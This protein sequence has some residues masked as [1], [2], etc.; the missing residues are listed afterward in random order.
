MRCLCGVRLTNPDCTL[1]CQ[2]LRWRRVATTALALALLLALAACQGGGGGAQTGAPE[3]PQAGGNTEPDPGTKQLPGTPTL[4]AGARIALDASEPLPA[5]TAAARPGVDF[6]SNRFICL[7]EDQPGAAALAPYLTGGIADGSGTG[8]ASTATPT[9]GQPQ[10]GKSGSA[11]LGGGESQTGAV[12]V[13]D[14][15]PLVQHPF[16]RQA[17]ANLARKYGLE[18]DRRVFYKGVDFAVYRLPEIDNITELDAMMLKVLKENVGLVQA[19]EYDFFRPADATP[20][21]PELTPEQRARIFQGNPAG[22]RGDMEADGRVASH[23]ASAAPNDPYHLNK[24]WTGSLATSG[25]WTNWRIGAVDGQAWNTT[26]GSPDVLVAVIDTGVRASHQDLDPNTIDPN[27]PT[28]ANTI[29]FPQVRAPGVYTDL[30]D[31]DN[32]PNDGDGHGTCCAGCIGAK[33]NNGIG[34]AGANWNVTILPLKVFSDTGVS[35]GSATIEAILLA[36]YLGADILSMSLGSLFPSQTERL[37]VKLATADGHLVIASAG[38]ENTSIPH[39]PAAYPEVMAVGATTLVNASNDQDFTLSG[40]ALPIATRYDARVYFSNYGPWVDIAAPGIYGVTTARDSDTMYASFAGTSMACPYV[41]GC[42]A[43]LWSHM[44]NPTAAEV[45]ALLLSSATEMAHLNNGADP[46]G[47]IDNTTNGTVRFC[48]AYAALQLYNNGNAPYPYPAP[49]VAWHDPTTPGATLTGTK[50]LQVAI[51]PNGNTIRR[52]VF[53]TPVRYLGTATTVAGSGYW[54]ISWDTAFEFNKDWPLTVTAYDDHGHAVGAVINIKTSNTH[55]ALSG[56]PPAWSQNFAGVANDAIPSGWYE[57]DGNAFAAANTSWGAATDAANPGL[58]PSMHSSGTVAN[59]ANNSNDWLIPPIIDLTHFGAPVLD[60]KCKYSDYYYSGDNVYVLATS[61]DQHYYQIGPSGASDVW[62]PLT[63]VSLSSFAGRE[64]RLMFVMTADDDSNAFTGLW[65]DDLK[66]NGA[67]GTPPSITINSPANGASAIGVQTINITVGAGT[68][69]VRLDCEPA[70]INGSMIWN[71]TQGTHNITWDSRWT[72][73]GGALLTITALNSTG[74]PTL[75]SSA[76]LALA[77]A[78]PTRNPPWLDSFDGYT[79][80]G[81][82]SGNSFISDW[83]VWWY[84][85]AVK[86]RTLGGQ[87]HTGSQCAYFGPAGGG[88]Y[89]ANENDRLYGPVHNLS[90]ATRPYLRLWHKL[91]SADTGDVGQITL[92]RYDGIETLELPLAEFHNSVSGWTRLV[93]DLTP[94]KDDPLRLKF[95]F[96]SD[97]DGSVGTGWY[98]DDYEVLD[99]NPTLA[100]L[101]PTSGLPGGA[102]TINGS[103]FGLVQDDSTV[104]FAA[105]GGGRVAATVTA[106]SDTQ[107]QVT[108]PATVASGNV[109]VNVLGF[110]SNGLPFTYANPTLTSIVP[111]RITVGSTVTLTGENF[112]VA[113]GAGDEVRFYSGGGYVAATAY[114]SWSNAQIVCTVPAGAATNTNGVWVHAYTKDSNKL[115]FTVVLGPPVLDGLEQR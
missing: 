7:F 67:T 112:G 79:D 106:W 51:T 86:W 58:A 50:T 88:N 56:S 10:E 4:A 43:L 11:E 60:Y 68:Q 64:L 107:I 76:Q 115:P 99:A 74:T 103:H 92:V 98:I 63:N 84:G 65:V 24:P 47:F 57:F 102:L 59:Y 78:N 96:T 61:D 18:L 27:D 73:N 38:N 22:F 53:N 113:R 34:L 89:G 75:Q 94:Y 72:Y 105:S 2:L 104:T 91:D 31:K 90:G 5:V 45:K 77:A 32:D 8:D 87:A 48:N 36:D 33:G 81:G 54:E 29:A 111:N 6:A 44:S 20:A 37:A 66:V 85:D 114:T 15:A 26:T 42:A 97:G 21:V 62:I 110:D 55:A 19:V 100:S 3:G 109:I 9:A 108:I 69:A 16:F 80:L 101:S 12:L 49:V 46:K 25:T 23:T 82:T 71:F 14:N 93:Y 13:T 35:G 39:Y 70:D 40:G 41:A 52:V 1:G 17:S 95:L 83:F 30:N 28:D